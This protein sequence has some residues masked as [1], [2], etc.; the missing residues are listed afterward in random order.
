MLTANGRE[1]DFRVAQ[2]TLLIVQPPDFRVKILPTGDKFSRTTGKPCTSFVNTKPPAPTNSGFSLEMQRGS[3]GAE[4]KKLQQFLK[5]QGYFTGRIDGSYGPITV[6][7]VRYFQEDYNLNVN[8]RV[9]TATLKRMNI[10]IA[11][12]SD[13]PYCDDGLCDFIKVLSPNGGESLVKGETTTLKWGAPS[14][15][16][17]VM[18]TL[19]KIYECN[20]TAGSTCIALY[21]S[22]IMTIVEKAPNNG[23]YK[24]TIPTNLEAGRYKINIDSYDKGKTL[25]DDSDAPFNIIGGILSTGTLYIDPNPV[26]VAAGSAVTVR[27]SYAPYCPPGLLCTQALYQVN[28]TWTIAN[29]NIAE[30]RPSNY[31]MGICPSTSP[32]P[33]PGMQVVGKSPGNTTLTATYVESN[34]AVSTKT[35][36][37]NV[38]FDGLLYPHN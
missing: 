5:E 30:V 3:R 15:I 23:F 24:W 27:A 16:N 25:G 36:P 14:Y 11:G 32:C 19:D 35:I 34:G 8:G 26:T 12:P 29:T 13:G 33:E 20:A 38:V 17:N 9:D 10:I 21:S 6:R 2:M 1:R 28:P 4:V 22:R 18:I 37:V 31:N 7:S